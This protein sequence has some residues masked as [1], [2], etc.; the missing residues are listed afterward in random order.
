MSMFHGL[1]QNMRQIQQ[2]MATNQMGVLSPTPQQSVQPRAFNFVPEKQPV[3]EK[4]LNRAQKKK[5]DQEL[6][7][8]RKKMERQYA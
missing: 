4:Q 6:L 5:L 3:Q 2:Q 8:K 7:E 1:N